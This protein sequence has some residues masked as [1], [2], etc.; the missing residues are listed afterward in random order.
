MVEKNSIYLAGWIDT[1]IHD[2]LV[3]IK[4]PA[5]GMSYALITTLDSCT[6]V[7]SLVTTS[8]HLRRLKHKCQVRGRGVLVPARELIA[9]ERRSRLFFGFDELWFFPSATSRPKPAGVAITGPTRITHTQLA[10]LRP[11]LRLTGCT[12]GLGDGTGMNFCVQAHG[13]AGHIIRALDETGS[14]MRNLEATDLVSGQPQI[15]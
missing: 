10:K 1:S 8:R 3:E 9:A 5:A 2:F 12:L 13:I 4:V 7:A 14:R 6:E 15:A 11:W